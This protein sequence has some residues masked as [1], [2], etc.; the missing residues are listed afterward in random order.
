MFELIIAESF[1]FL[2][3]KP[4]KKFIWRL[5]LGLL[6]CFSISLIIPVVAF[7]SVFCSFLFVLMFAS[8]VL[9]AYFIFDESLKKILFFAIAGYTIQHI[10]QEIYEVSTLFIKFDLSVST[11]GM[12]SS[13]EFFTGSPWYLIF[14]QYVLYAQFFFIVYF[15]AFFYVSKK[16]N[17]EN[18]LELDNSMIILFVGLLVLIDI[19]FSSIIIYSL[20]NN[21]D[22]TARGLLDIFN[23]VCSLVA[24][25][26]LFEMPRRKKAETDYVL[27]RKIHEREKNQYQ[28]TKDNIEA[29]NIKYHDLKHIIR[30]ISKN[31]VNAEIIEEFDKIIEEYDTL[32][33]TENQALNVVLSDKNMICKKRNIAFSSIVDATCLSFISEIDIFILFGNILDNAIE[34]VSSLKEE[35]RIIE[36]NVMKRYDFVTINVYNTFDGKNK[37]KY[38][39]LVTTKN[40]SQNHGFGLKSIE[41]IANKYNGE[42]VIKMQDGIFDL[43]LIFFRH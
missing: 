25:I 5:L 11:G 1:L 42:L 19:I 43:T 9:A 36:L 26:L 35:K 31:G 32:Y 12:Y 33:K 23:I 40:D 39:K 15:I 16:I 4:R 29:L 7:N 28:I 37:T 41:N 21:I 13:N 27:L 18:S 17:K 14:L 6:F 30:Q 10:A 22:K 8:T 34:A 3:L 2:Y 24:F 38:N 20:P